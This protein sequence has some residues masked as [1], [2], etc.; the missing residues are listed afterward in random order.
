MNGSDQ[1]NNPA[2]AFGKSNNTDGWWVS[3]KQPNRNL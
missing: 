2:D 1:K 3:T